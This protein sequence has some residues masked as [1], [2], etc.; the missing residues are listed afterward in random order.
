MS[1]TENTAPKAGRSV[2]PTTAVPW[3]V[4]AVLLI[5]LWRE[6]TPSAAGQEPRAPE[7]A[8]VPVLDVAPL[9]AGKTTVDKRYIGY[10]KPV[11]S[12][13]LLPFISGFVEDILVEN[14]QN[15]RAGDLLMTLEQSR[16]RAQTDEAR[17]AL[18][19][20][21]ATLENAEAYLARVRTAGKQAVSQADRDKAAADYLTAK[22][23]VAQ[24]EAA[25]NAA[26]VLYGYTIIRAPISGR[27]GT[28]APGKGAYVS[29]SG[30]PMA[31]IVQTSP[32]YVVFSLPDKE[33]SALAN[34]NGAAD[35]LK[36][37]RIALKTSDGKTY[38]L[39]GRFAYAENV[40][41]KATGSVAVYALFDNPSAVLMPNSYVDVVVS[42][43]YDGVLIDQDSVALTPEGKR[44]RVA[45]NRSVR[46]E[47]VDEIAAVG[48]KYLIR[49]TFEQGD[50][51]V[52]SINGKIIE[53]QPFKLNI[54]SENKE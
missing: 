41:D 37:R 9:A 49:N 47:T 17:A 34:E 29:P 27:I 39:T 48:A 2:R 53:N 54:I 21:R 42:T 32:V 44:I 3:I 7:S 31:E 28:V 10:V 40:V 50:Y 20:A 52:K 45:N 16:Y 13:S 23:S 12:V 46:T 19:G 1:E 22:A 24:A 35:L 43:T 14:G 30:P 18:A 38:P 33:F 5:L 51:L 25:L 8:A 36:D 15:V 6:K 26:L 11:R 4:I